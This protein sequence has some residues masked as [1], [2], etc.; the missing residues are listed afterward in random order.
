MFEPDMKDV[1]IL[2]E[3][4]NDSRKSFREIARKIGIATSTLI[5]RFNTMKKEGIIK[6]STLEIDYEKLGYPLTA[7]IEVMVSKGKLIEVENKI[8]KLPNVYGVYDLTGESDM[9]ILARFKTRK[10]LNA[11]IK[12]ELVSEHIER[13][14]T[15][16][17]LNAVKEEYNIL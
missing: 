14:N 3:L 17:I 11:F 16:L 7:L 9:I 13:T 10:D 5:K 6:S 2:K 15:R 4:C 8:A 12:S 1:E